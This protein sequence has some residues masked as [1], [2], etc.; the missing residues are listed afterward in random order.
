MITAK[1]VQRPDMA[2]I[3]K[4]VRFGTAM[5]LTRTA[6]QGQE[7]VTDAVRTSFTYRNNW[8]VPSNKFGIRIKSATRDDLSAEVKTQATWLKKQKKGG[9][10]TAESPVRQFRYTYDGQEFIARPSKEL[11]PV[12]STK[13]LS[14]KLWPSALKKPF[15]I[16]TKKGVYLLCQRYGPEPRD[17]AVMYILD[18]V[19]T[20][21]LKDAFYEPIQKVVDKNLQTNIRTGIDRALATMR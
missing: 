12:G 5:G 7:A 16:K 4:N 17:I 1:L 20:I 21:K 9:S 18:P 14:K 2:K 3:L 15:V 19:V 6:K 10:V 8:L 13:V 11:R